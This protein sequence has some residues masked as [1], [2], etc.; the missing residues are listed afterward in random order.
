M[1]NKVGAR[2]NRSTDFFSA[3]STGGHM[4]VEVLTSQPVLDCPGAPRVEF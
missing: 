3:G 2:V 4:H 1:L